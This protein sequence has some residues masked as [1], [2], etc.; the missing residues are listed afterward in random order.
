VALGAG[1]LTL[2]T[3]TA[4]AVG[5]PTDVV[6]RAILDFGKDP[7]STAHGIGP[8]PDPELV[9]QFTAENGVFAVWVATSSSGVVCYAMSD[10]EWDGEGSPTKDQLSSYGCGGEIYVGP[11]RPPEELTR[12]DQLGGFFKDD[13]GPLV[14]GVSPYLDAV[15]VSV[16]GTGVDRTL[17]VDP[18]SHGYG[19][20]LPEAEHAATVTLTFTDAEGRVLGAKRSTA[21]IG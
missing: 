6:K 1:A 20:A 11:G 12:A 10:G 2:T 18:E 15:S 19:A 21:P 5:G 14:Y 7:N 8:L 13:D 17:P 9:A 16:Q 4:V 3:A